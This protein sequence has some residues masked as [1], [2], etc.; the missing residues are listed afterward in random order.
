MIRRSCCMQPRMIF[1]HVSVGVAAVI[2]V[3]IFL[4]QHRLVF[5]MPVFDDMID[6]C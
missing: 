2:R 4:G 5:H 3:V 1:V 6:Y